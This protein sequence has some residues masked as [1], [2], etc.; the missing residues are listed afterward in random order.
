MLVIETPK[1]GDC[2]LFGVIANTIVGGVPLHLSSGF[3][4][5]FYAEQPRKAHA[6]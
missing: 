2:D 6:G 1:K 3:S 5:L 4:V